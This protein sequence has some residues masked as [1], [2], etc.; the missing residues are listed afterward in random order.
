MSPA[1]MI[2]PVASFEETYPVGQSFG[3]ILTR[4][5]VMG[6]L[7]MHDHARHKIALALAFLVMDSE[8]TRDVLGD[9]DHEGILGQVETWKAVQELLRAL[10]QSIEHA[11]GRSLVTVM[12]ALGPE[13]AAE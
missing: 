9:E 5:D 4:D 6:F 10:D 11:I 1:I 12:E 7:D 3:A 8:T 2:P 13:S